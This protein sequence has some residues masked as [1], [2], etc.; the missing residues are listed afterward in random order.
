MCRIILGVMILLLALPVKADFT[1]GVSYF[2][3]Q[4]YTQAF[5]EFKPLADEGDERAQYYAAYLYLNGY[6]VA[7]DSKEG[8]AYLQ[9]SLDQ[10]YSKAMTLM[11]YLHSEGKYMPK[12]K[13]KALELYLA[14]AEDG[15]NDALLNLGVMY[16]TGDGVKKDLEKAV[17]YFSRVDLASKPVVGRY[18][19]DIYQYSKDETERKKAR[20]YYMSAASNGDLG[21]YSA[22]AYM[23]Q[24]GREGTRNIDKAMTYYKYAASQSYAPAQ[25]A[26]GTIYANGDGVA[27]D[28]IKG[29]AWL[30]L[31]ANQGLNVAVQA[32]K[33]LETN[34]TLTEL[35]LARREVIELQRNV[36]GQIESPLKDYVLRNTTVGPQDGPHKK[37]PRSKRRVRVKAKQKES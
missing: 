4:Q 15:D 21:A 5:A 26:L 2:D 30:S 32:Q 22:L 6:G 36:L 14:A 17:E 18:L 35:D 29:Y 23:D 37:R 31:A 25:Y 33:Q 20:D 9:K 19:G 34:M 12:N 13:A 11:G 1:E 7:L 8:V 24:M 10:G 3:N 27:R 16:Y 28:I